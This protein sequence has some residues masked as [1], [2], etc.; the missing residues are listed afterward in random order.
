MIK[1]IPNAKNRL[2]RSAK[3]DAIIANPTKNGNK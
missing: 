1:T 2:Y 3:T